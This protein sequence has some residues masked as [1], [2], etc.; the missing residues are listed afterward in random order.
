VKVCSARSVVAAFG[1]RSADA[2]P[3]CAPRYQASNG[4]AFG[5]AFATAK[6]LSVPAPRLIK[7]LPIQIKILLT[8]DELM[9]VLSSIHLHERGRFSGAYAVARWNPLAITGLPNAIVGVLAAA[10]A[11][12]EANSNLKS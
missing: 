6:E 2:D 5:T 4:V 3:R 8:S 11:N 1:Y 7:I 12:G 9:G 10:R